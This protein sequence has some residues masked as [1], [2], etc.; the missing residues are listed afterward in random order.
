MST[1]WGGVHLLIV[2]VVVVV[3]VVIVVVTVVVVLVVVPGDGGAVLVLVA[4][5]LFLLNAWFI[6]FFWHSN[7]LSTFFYPFLSEV[8]FN[9]TSS[10][11]LLLL[12]LSAAATCRLT[13]TVA[14]SF[15]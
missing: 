15:Q 1:L 6:H 13:R 12:C 9:C 8:L 10:I 7:F 5:H 4:V 2:V 3:V 11:F 14:R